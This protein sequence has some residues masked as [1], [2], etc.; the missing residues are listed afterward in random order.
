MG[1]DPVYVAGGVPVFE[2]VVSLLVGAAEAFAGFGEDGVA[3]LLFLVGVY[4]VGFN[5]KFLGLVGVLGPFVLGFLIAVGA[6][7]VGA[8]LLAVAAVAVYAGECRVELAGGVLPFGV[9]VGVGGALDGLCGFAE[10]LGFPA[11]V[12]E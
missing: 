6:L 10:A 5:G 3:D 4:A 9:F 11:F 1:V 12:V 2:V 7:I 8:G